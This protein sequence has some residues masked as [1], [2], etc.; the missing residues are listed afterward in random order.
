M[1]APATRDYF[2]ELYVAALFGDAGWS[3]YFPK[4]DVGFD[5]IATKPVV[6]QVLI[7]PVQ[8]KGLYPTVGKKDKATYGFKGELTALHDSMVLVLPYFHSANAHAPEHIA[9]M[10][11]DQ[12]K[13]TV[14]G[15]VRC[16]PA[17]FS[18]GHAVPRRD[19]A[20]Y[21]GLSGLALIEA[22]NWGSGA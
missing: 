6:G 17:V 11:R 16:V 21:F 19:S 5:F 18:S 14:S 15:G 12:C 13:L 1:P 3:V 10:P 20:R 9:F 2:A 7:R 22:A 8:I 4:R